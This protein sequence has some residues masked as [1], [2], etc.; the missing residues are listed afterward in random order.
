LI[1]DFPKTLPITPT[2]TYEIYRGPFIRARMGFHPEK[3]FTRVVFDLREPI[4]YEI[5]AKE[6]MTII[7]IR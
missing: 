4:E 5:E 1:V 2:K 7:R 3:A 6:K